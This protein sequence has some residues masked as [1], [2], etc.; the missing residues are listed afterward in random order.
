MVFGGVTVS[1]AAQKASPTARRLA[2][3]KIRLNNMTENFGYEIRGSEQ[4]V[5][6]E[7]RKNVAIST[8]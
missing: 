7:T 5:A 6:G 4:N 1:S 8:P 2:A 3:L